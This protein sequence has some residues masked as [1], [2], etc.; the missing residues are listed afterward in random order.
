MVV[1]RADVQGAEVKTKDAHHSGIVIGVPGQRLTCPCGGL[2]MN[3][4]PS[5]YLGSWEMRCPSCDTTLA[6]FPEAL[7]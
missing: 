1:R 6:Q 4:E 5:P 3:V 2:W 7:A